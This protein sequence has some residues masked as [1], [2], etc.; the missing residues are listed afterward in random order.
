MGI[1]GFGLPRHGELI[2]CRG[3]VYEW[4]VIEEVDEYYERWGWCVLCSASD[5]FS[6]YK[7]KSVPVVEELPLFD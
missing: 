2:A 1:A 4:D 5:S 7:I 3:I 6:L